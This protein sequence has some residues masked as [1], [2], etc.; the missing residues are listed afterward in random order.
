MLTLIRISCVK[1]RF[2]W[3]SL[4][5]CVLLYHQV[6]ANESITVVTED[7]PP[8]SYRLDN[9]DIGGIATEKIKQVLAKA[10]IPYTLNLYPWA[11]SYEMA[12]TQKNVLVYSIYRHDKREPLFHWLCPLLPKVKLYFFALVKN[13]HIEIKDIEDV[14]KYTVGL[15]RREVAASFLKEKGFKE[16]KNLYFSADDYINLNQLLKGQVDIIVTTARSIK[17]RLKKLNKDFNQ[18]K[19]FYLEELNAATENCMAFNLNTSAELVDKVRRALK[20]INVVY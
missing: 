2:I 5:S 15:V 6:H 8:Y 17:M 10:D 9:G 1:Q 11:R 18:V 19:A 4:L 7:W 14:R 12:L 13:R 20:E 3:F 16:G